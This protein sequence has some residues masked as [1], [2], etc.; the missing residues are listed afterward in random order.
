MTSLLAPAE[1]CKAG[2]SSESCT[3]AAA[4]PM[5]LHKLQ[6]NNIATG[7][8]MTSLLGPAEEWEPHT[9]IPLHGCRPERMLCQSQHKCVA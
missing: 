8:F 3:A 5:L 2:Q 4:S 1:E 9:E 7:A 6:A